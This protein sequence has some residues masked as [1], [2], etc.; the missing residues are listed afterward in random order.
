MEVL[1]IVFASIFMSFNYKG[2]SFLDRL[3]TALGLSVILVIF[4]KAM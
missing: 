1:A 4:L 3:S 2:I